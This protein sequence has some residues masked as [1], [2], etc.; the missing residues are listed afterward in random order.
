MQTQEH[1]HSFWHNLVVWLVPLPLPT[2]APSGEGGTVPGEQMG[3]S[4]SSW[5]TMY[6]HHAGLLSA[7]VSKEPLGLSCLC[8]GELLSQL[9]Q[10]GGRQKWQALP[11]SVE[12]AVGSWGPE[13]MFP[14]VEHHVGAAKLSPC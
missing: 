5:D 1:V 8:S 10:R 9:V 11:P 12:R 7:A 13:A 14:A 4:G 2:E 3:R 6:D